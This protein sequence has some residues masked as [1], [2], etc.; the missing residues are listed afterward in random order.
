M[1]LLRTDDPSSGLNHFLYAGKQVGVIV[2]SAENRSH[3]LFQLLVDRVQLGQP[4]GGDERTDQPC[5]G[6]IDAF[7]E[8][9]AEHCKADALAVFG[10]PVEKVLALCLAHATGLRPQ[11][12]P[13]VP[14]GQQLRHLLQIIETA[15]KR[16]VITGALAELSGDQVHDRFERGLAMNEPRGDLVDDV[17]LQLIGVK[18]RLDVDAHRVL[19]RSQ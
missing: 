18:R 3:A 19:R 12:D 15:E 6:Q 4:Q 5:A 2:A 8:R 11:F 14:L 9:T 10:E 1:I 7:A 16:Q 17:H 13:R